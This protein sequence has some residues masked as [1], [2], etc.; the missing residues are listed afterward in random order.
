M[1]SRSETADRTNSR[2]LS[3][4]ESEPIFRPILQP[5][6]CLFGGDYVSLAFRPK[7]VRPM[8]CRVIDSELPDASPNSDTFDF[9]IFRQNNFPEVAELFG[10]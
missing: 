5:G 10:D 4:L 3:L 2:Y 1:R 8:P 7:E 6:P 9:R